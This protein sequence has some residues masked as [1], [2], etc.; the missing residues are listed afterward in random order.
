MANL[1]KFSPPVNTAAQTT[2]ANKIFGNGIDGTVVISTNTFLS[3]D[4]YYVNLTVNSG[5]TLFTNG[6]RIFVNGTLT[7]SGTVG[8][9][10]GISQTTS[11]L[12]GSLLT[13]DDGTA[14]YSSAD[15][16]TGSLTISHVK[17]YESL[18]YGIRQDGTQLKR[19]Y[20]GVTGT[21]G[22]DGA[23]GTDGTANAGGAAGGGSSTAG[24]AGTAGTKGTKGLK[25]AKGQAGGS[26]L[27]V[28]N[29]IT[30][31]GTFI[32]KGTIASAANPGN[33]GNPGVAGT[34][35]HTVTGTAYHNPSVTHPTSHPTEHPAHNPDVAGHTAGHHYNVANIGVPYHVASPG[36]PGHNATTY[37]TTGV[38]HTAAHH[39]A[40]RNIA[41]KHGASHNPASH[42]AGS[43][44][45][46]PG[47]PFHNPTT[48][49]Q[50]HYIHANHYHPACCT[51]D[52][53]VH[54][55]GTAYT[56]YGTG[57]G[58][59]TAPGNPAH[60]P[61]YPGGAAGTANPGNPGT[62]GN[63]ATDGADGSLV[64]L[65]KSI[66]T[67]VATSNVTLVTDIDS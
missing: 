18:V 62:A 4:M 53:P 24:T 59:A 46:V 42:F 39:T 13:R 54:H 9:P 31:S 38:R 56:A 17:D 50:K 35:G 6:F 34:A 2:R 12:A 32:S 44:V 11:V 33:P 60:N 55:I 21:D 64:I 16:I 22:T 67:H 29:V 51:P 63:A 8:M 26:V 65:T 10:A 61:T 52:T 58:H 47:N 40:A 28:A 14:G 41:P 27:V 48:H 37:Y 36:N 57:Y 7:N 49:S 1:Q 19:W 43:L 66:A 30:G 5:I 25:G 15:S 3:R 45:T 23:D 20:A